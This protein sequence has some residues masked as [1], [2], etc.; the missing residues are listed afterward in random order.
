MEYTLFFYYY[1]TGVTSHVRFS[2]FDSACQK[3]ID[4]HPFLV[5]NL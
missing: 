2:T 3:D 1:T 4:S 5:Y